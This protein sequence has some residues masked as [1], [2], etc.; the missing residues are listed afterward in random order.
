[1]NKRMMIRII[2]DHALNNWGKDNGWDIIGMRLLQMRKFGNKFPTAFT[3]KMRF[4]LLMKFV[5]QWI[6]I[7][8]KDGRQLIW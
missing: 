6:R 1:M 3:P 7:V 4:K 8:K 2:K 5:K